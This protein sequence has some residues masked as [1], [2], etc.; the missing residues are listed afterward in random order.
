MACQVRQP[1]RLRHWFAKE[2]RNFGKNV[3]GPLFGVL[4]M[5]KGVT[6]LRAATARVPRAHPRLEV[7]CRG[8]STAL[9]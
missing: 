4:C 6:L 8:V 7:L 2:L 1:L 3:S 5:H 9:D